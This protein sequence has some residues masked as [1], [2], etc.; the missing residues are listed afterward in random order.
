MP[1]LRAA[2]A[3]LITLPTGCASIAVVPV[4]CEEEHRVGDVC[5]GVPPGPVCDEDYWTEGVPCAVV[6]QVDSGASFAAAVGSAQAGSCIALAPG[7]YGSV[8]LPPGVS[9]LGG[10]ADCVT[11]AGIEVSGEGVVVRGV[12]I[13]AGSLQVRDG[14]TTAEMIRIVDS[15]EDGV[16]VGSGA[17]LTL[18]ASE[19]R[20][21]ARYGVSA[22]DVASLNVENSLIEETLDG[23]G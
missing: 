16:T 6:H 5:A 9:L 11:L 12:T 17:T 15:L 7:A 1:R 3:F 13:T 4:D 8:I 21:F 10:G 22:F 20:S 19:V 2:L 23:P 14:S 18:R